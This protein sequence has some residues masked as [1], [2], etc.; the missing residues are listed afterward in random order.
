MH[1]RSFI[2]FVVAMQLV[3]AGCSPLRPGP[4]QPPQATVES[5]GNIASPAP[6]GPTP[7]DTPV[8]IVRVTSGDRALF[9]GDYEAA[10]AEYEAA[11]ASLE[12]D[13]VRTAA[14]VGT[15]PRAVLRW[16]V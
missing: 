14:P 1:M 2:A 8:P 11:A 4:G 16:T 5:G 7:E 3:L 15:G 10:A 12:D 13:A 6:A 9:N